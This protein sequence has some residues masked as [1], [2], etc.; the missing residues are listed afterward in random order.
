MSKIFSLLTVAVLAIVALFAIGA[1]ATNYNF[2]LDIALRGIKY[3]KISYCHG[4]DIRSWTCPACPLH[5]N[6]KVFNVYN[7]ASLE[8]QAYSGY[9]STN[10]EIVVAFRGS[11]NLINWIT[12]FT[13]SWIDYPYCSGC[14][15]HK[16]FWE[17][18]QS[19]EVPIINDV[20]AMLA[21]YPGASIG[22][23]SHSLGA[24]VN[25]HAVATF[26]RLQLAPV[27]NEYSFGTP[28]TGNVQWSE[29][30]ALMARTS[31]GRTQRIVN[32]ADPVPHLPLLSMG[33]WLHTPH[34]TWA[35]EGGTSPLV[36]CNDY[37]GHE[38]PDCSDSIIIPNPEDHLHYL[39]FHTEC[40]M[41]EGSTPKTKL[42]LT[43]EARAKLNKMF[44]KEHMN[45]L[46]KKKKH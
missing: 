42:N 8:S 18:W 12:D 25:L 26:N 36:D 46:S 29:W 16:G 10:N 1:N 14:Q 27:I 40:E 6:F 3:A 2:Q 21:K 30:V 31:Q 35:K 9:D 20:R 37:P 15:V 7:N 45:S 19:Y 43:P 11:Q 41:T 32:K 4:S 17:E 22:C 44:R 23:Y 28:R 34:E 5:P 13:F 33:P 24:A 39:G 38:D